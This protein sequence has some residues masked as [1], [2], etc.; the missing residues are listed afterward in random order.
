ME[1]TEDLELVGQLHSVFRYQAQAALQHTLVYAK[2]QFICNEN[3]LAQKQKFYHDYKVVVC[4]GTEAGNGA[5]ALKPVEEAMA[6]LLI[7]HH[8]IVLGVYNRRYSQTMDR[9]FH[10]EKPETPETYSQHS[11]YSRL[12]QQEMKS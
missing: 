3:L 8:H 6:E 1:S 10:A 9:Y 11:E 12:G 5:D 2:R 4:A 7:P